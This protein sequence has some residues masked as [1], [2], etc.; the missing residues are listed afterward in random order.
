MRVKRLSCTAFSGEPWPTKIDGARPRIA[1]RSSAAM[2][3]G[4]A[5][6]ALCNPRAS[7]PISAKP[8]PTAMSWRRR[9]IRG[10]TPPRR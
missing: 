4:V 1:G 6:S 10:G 3:G 5:A 8:A 9:V 7:V 2:G